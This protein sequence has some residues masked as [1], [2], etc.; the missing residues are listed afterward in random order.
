M[1][2]GQP[3]VLINP[4]PK[5]RCCYICGRPVDE[6]EA[7]GG[8]GDP[9]VG[10]WKGAKLIRSYREEL[11]GT[12]GSSWECRDCVVRDGGLWELE[13]EK[14]LGRSMTAEEKLEF[15]YDFWLS[16][17]EAVL[18]RNLSDDE[19]RDLGCSPDTWAPEGLDPTPVAE[20]SVSVR[21]TPDDMD[22]VERYVESMRPARRHEV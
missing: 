3:V 6:L 9:L 1:N 13:E 16:Y 12:V 2:D 4:P 14:R 7:F 20:G 5:D 17:W 18:G 8:P 19:R 21:L 22:D 15:R 11:P 10:D